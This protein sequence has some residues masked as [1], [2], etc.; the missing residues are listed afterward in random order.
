MIMIVKYHNHTLVVLQMNPQHHEAEPQN[1][2]N[3]KTPERQ[4]KVKHPEAHVLGVKI[5]WIFFCGRRGL[6]LGG[7][8][9]EF[10]GLFLRSM[11]RIRINLMLLKF[12]I[13]FGACRMFQ[14]LVVNFLVDAG[15]KPAYEEK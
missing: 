15:S 7:H 2:N 8:L 9:Y 13:S 6:V 4:R 12:Q 3:H 1:N 14:I 5:L 10:Y 11:Y